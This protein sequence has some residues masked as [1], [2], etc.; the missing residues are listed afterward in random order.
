M[1]HP[2][3]PLRASSL[4]LKLLVA[5][6][7]ELVGELRGRR[8]SDGFGEPVPDEN[9][10]GAAQE[11]SIA[12]RVSAIESNELDRVNAALEK[13]RVGTYGS[14]EHCG[15]PISAARLKA[16]PWAEHCR[17]CEAQSPQ[18]QVAAIGRTH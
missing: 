7:A 10:P 5:K 15:S 2:N 16:I 14:C 18:E 17:K 3:R 6:Q 1:K 13:L 9:R 11:S 12:E 4:C 8:G